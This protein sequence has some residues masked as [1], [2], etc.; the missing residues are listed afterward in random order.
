M[1]NFILIASALLLFSQISTAAQNTAVSS[2]KTDSQP[3]IFEIKELMKVGFNAGLPEGKTIDKDFFPQ[4][5]TP[6]MIA[7]FYGYIDSVKN[8]ISKGANVNAQT[9]FSENDIFEYSQTA[10]SY[11]VDKNQT[12]IVKILLDNKA[13][14]SNDQKGSTPLVSACANGNIDIV[15][16]LITHGADVNIPAGEDF[17]PLFAATIN[18]KPEI[19]EILVEAGANLEYKDFNDRDIFFYAEESGNPKITSLINQKMK[20]GK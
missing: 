4:G 9:D 13:K 6:L 20:K 19:V 3:G 1:K 12:E 14:V 11:A 5:T 8:L 18:N 15:K 2:N 7:S 10:L 16:M 17:T